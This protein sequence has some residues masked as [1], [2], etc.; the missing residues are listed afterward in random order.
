MK[1]SL[2]NILILALP[3]LYGG[4]NSSDSNGQLLEDRVLASVGS[5]VLYLSDLDKI[6][7]PSTSQKDSV[8]IATA[9]IDQWIRDQLMTREAARHFTSDF[10]IEKLVDDYR[11]KLLTHNL[12]EQVVRMRFD[13]IVSEG[14]LTGFYEEMKEQFPLGDDVYR[15]IYA[16]FDRTGDNLTRVNDLWNEE[17]MSEFLTYTNL[18][19]SE[20]RIDTSQWFTLQ[21]INSW[22]GNWSQSRIFNL[23]RQKQIDGEY[24]I[25]LKVLDLREK[26]AASPFT[27][28]EDQLLKMLLHRR[29]QN[30][31][32]KFKE[33]LYEKGLENNL[34]KLPQ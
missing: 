19:S 17:N 31:L 23:S 3:F 26:G 30:I 21:Q 33:E 15:C 1:Y 32:R 6:I 27:Y 28:V 16:K 12:E 4:C 22:Y 14:E 5:R 2:L 20:S 25:F 8:A 7:H 11:E 24:E 13:T 10:E 29:K 9:Y 18:Y 34:I